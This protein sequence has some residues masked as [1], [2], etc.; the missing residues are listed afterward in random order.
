MRL[1]LLFKKNSDNEYKYLFNLKEEGL[2]Q[3]FEA[4][5][6]ELARLSSTSAWREPKRPS[7]LFK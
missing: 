1:N 3:W 4:N 2:D 5:E 6:K 7:Q